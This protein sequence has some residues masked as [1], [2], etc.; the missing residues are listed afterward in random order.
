MKRAS[1]AGISAS[2]RDDSNLEMI[3]ASA[4]AKEGNLT[5]NIKYAQTAKKKREIKASAKKTNQRQSSSLLL[6]FDVN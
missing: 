4:T 6:S 3:D 5:S 2:E 1:F